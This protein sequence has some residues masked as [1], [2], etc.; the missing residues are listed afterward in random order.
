MSLFKK[1]LKCSVIA[2]ITGAVCLPPAAVAQRIISVN[3]N[4]GNG[5]VPMSEL[6]LAGAPGVRTNNWNNFPAGNNRTILGEDLVFAD[7]TTVGAPFSIVVA[8]PPAWTAE[9]TDVNDRLMYR[10]CYQIQSD[11]GTVTITFEDIPFK[12]YQIYVYISGQRNRGGSVQLEGDQIY[13][14]RGDVFPDEDGEG[15]L[16]A[17]TIS[18]DPEN[19]A[20]VNNGNYVMYDQ[21]EGKTQT[22]TCTA[23]KELYQTDHA[24]FNLFGFQIIELEDDRTTMIFIE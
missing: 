17:T 24:R 2:V 23:Y 9:S 7:G 12:Y 19:P 6:D 13:Y 10:G 11:E 1:T 15:Y 20:A 3:V 5:R 22:V 18:V 4:E 8:G 16:H 14:I 21:L